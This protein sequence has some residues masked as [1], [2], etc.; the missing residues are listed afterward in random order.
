MKQNL[1]DNPEATEHREKIAHWKKTKTTNKM[2]EDLWVRAVELARS[3]TP[4]RAASFFNIGY[5]ELLQR[6]PTGK[7]EIRVQK[8]IPHGFVELPSLS[9]SQTRTNVD[10][11]PQGSLEFLI[12]NDRGQKATVRGMASSSDWAQVFSGWLQA[13]SSPEERSK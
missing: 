10:P 11:S 4:S 1:S 6:M 2:P 12:S 7:P 8:K 5:R 13:S 3:S 9:P